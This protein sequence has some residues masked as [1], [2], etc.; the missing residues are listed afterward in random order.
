MNKQWEYEGL[1]L[2][3]VYVGDNITK[4]SEMGAD[5]W[6]LVTVDNGIAYMKRQLANDHIDEV[7]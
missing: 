1:L 6:E 7:K 4:M 5:G 3:T 2:S